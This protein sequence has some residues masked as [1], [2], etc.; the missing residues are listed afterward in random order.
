MCNDIDGVLLPDCLNGYL[1]GFP[2]YSPLPPAEMVL[3]SKSW[4]T[5]YKIFVYWQIS[6][7]FLFHFS[8]I[9]STAVRDSAQIEK[10]YRKHLSP[11]F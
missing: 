2:L 10:N 5:L 1:V 11:D 8:M 4:D 7:L 3:I 6:S 9:A